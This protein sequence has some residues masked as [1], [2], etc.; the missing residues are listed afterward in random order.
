MKEI[1]T[2]GRATIVDVRPKPRFAGEVAEPRPGLRSG[3]I[4]GSL[5]LPFLDLLGEDGKMKAEEDLKKCFREAG[6]AVPRATVFSCGSGMTAA[7][8][9]LAMLEIGANNEELAIY[10]GSWVEWGDEK[11]AGECPVEK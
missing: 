9:R 4:A 2:A 3:H 8:G 6:I 11:R 10:D 7:I 5:N 1:T